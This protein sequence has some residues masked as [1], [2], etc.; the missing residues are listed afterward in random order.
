MCQLHDLKVYR[1]ALAVMS[2]NW[3]IKRTY[4]N[5]AKKAAQDSKNKLIA[6][7]YPQLL[8]L[9]AMTLSAGG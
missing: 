3:R 1:G 5:H 4:S 8:F 6:G 9:N 2:H 7:H